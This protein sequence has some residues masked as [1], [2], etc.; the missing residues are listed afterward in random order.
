[1]SK[2]S[3]MSGFPSIPQRIS[4]LIN[5]KESLNLKKEEADSAETQLAQASPNPSSIPSYLTAKIFYLEKRVEYLSGLQRALSELEQKGSISATEK[6]KI[7]HDIERVKL[8]LSGEALAIKLRERT[9]I[10]DM[11]DYMRSS[12]KPDTE[13]AYVAAVT[14]TVDL[15]TGKQGKIRFGGFKR[16]ALE[17]YGASKPSSGRDKETFC[18]L[19]GWKEAV[20]VRAAHIVPQSL[21]GESLVHLFGTELEPAKDPR[22]GMSASAYGNV[23]DLR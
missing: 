11:G 20:V 16:N 22:N 18:H 21:D 8:P 23:K 12:S 1:M 15:R 6:R 2:M 19:L 17:F 5:T 7:E 13:R 3:K 10:E 4:E 14:N 9:I